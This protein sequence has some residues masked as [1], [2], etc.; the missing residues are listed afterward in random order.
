[1]ELFELGSVDYPFYLINIRIPYKK[2][3]QS[4]I[5]SSDVNADI[6]RLVGLELVVSAF[7]TLA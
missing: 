4:V 5:S 7:L 3:N 2:G 6:G 1:M